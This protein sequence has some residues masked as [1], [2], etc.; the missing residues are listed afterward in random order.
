MTYAG[1]QPGLEIV[2]EYAGKW[3]YIQIGNPPVDLNPSSLFARYLNAITGDEFICVNNTPGANIWVKTSK[4]FINQGCIIWLSGML[5]NGEAK[6][7]L[8][9]QY[10][11]TLTDVSITNEIVEGL[12]RKAFNFNGTTSRIIFDLLESLSIVTSMSFGAWFYGDFSGCVDNAVIAELGG[13]GE[14]LTQNILSSL[15]VN[16]V[17]S[18]LYT[19]AEYGAG[20]NVVPTYVG[21]TPVVPTNTWCYLLFSKVGTTDV[22]MSIYNAVTKTISTFQALFNYS[23]AK[24]LV[25]DKRLGHHLFLPNMPLGR[26]VISGFGIVPF[27]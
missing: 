25:A 11:N 15:R 21:P 1:N 8:G 26:F 18:E 6:N 3:D 4:D 7:A 10:G 9:Y 20:T 16:Y 2:Q 27:R 22:N 12:P 19:F 14:A 5:E 17:N 24:S 23:A 13:N